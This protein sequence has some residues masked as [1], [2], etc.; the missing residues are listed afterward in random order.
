MLR[1]IS[2][3]RQ[4]RRKTPDGAT[5]PLHTLNNL[6]SYLTPM[7]PAKP[8]HLFI[9]I[10]LLITACVHHPEPFTQKTYTIAPKQTITISQLHLSITNEGCGRQWEGGAEKPFCGLII[11]HKDST[12]RAGQNAAPIYTGTIKIEIDK[13]NPW[14]VA[15]DSVPPGGCR[16]IVTKLEDNSR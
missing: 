16:L 2:V 10:L 12:I 8:S 11:K 13:M 15:E 5:H 6:F 14:G 9:L 1:G 3:S 4:N 7:P